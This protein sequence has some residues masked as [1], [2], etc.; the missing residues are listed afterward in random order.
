VPSPPDT[1]RLVVR[2]PADL[3]QCL[4]LVEVPFAA[5]PT[6]LAAERG[7]RIWGVDMVLHLRSP[8]TA[9]DR[10]F[11]SALRASPRR[12]DVITVDGPDLDLVEILQ[13][14][15]VARADLIVARTALAAVGRLVAAAPPGDP[16]A[17][18]LDHVRAEA[19]D[20]TELDLLADI[21]NGAIV[22][23]ADRDTAERLLGAHGR[24]VR[25]RLG[26]QKNATAREIRKAVREAA[27]YWRGK[28]EHPAI[29]SLERDAC[30]ILIRT[31][32]GLAQ[33]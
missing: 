3:L 30:N 8:D 17:R 9:A 2:W 13:R 4:T 24:D 33:V 10:A 29:G 7:T 26:L 27:A 22:L 1:E 32:E 18:L 21:E 14:R 12:L 19:H 28:A 23:H 16:V 25:T 6:V 31:C 15:V 11:R 20:L 5:D